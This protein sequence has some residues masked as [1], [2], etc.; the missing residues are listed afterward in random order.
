MG[1]PLLT[2]SVFVYNTP[3]LASAKRTTVPCNYDSLSPSLHPCL[4]RFKL[5]VTLVMN[6]PSCLLLPLGNAHPSQTSG[7]PRTHSECGLK[8]TS[9]TVSHGEMHD[10]DLVMLPYVCCLD[11]HKP[12]RSIPVEWK[13]QTDG[14][15][16]SSC[17]CISWPTLL[18]CGV[19]N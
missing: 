4:Y 12:R 19:R 1:L 18:I 16:G 6:A 7:Q 11:R 10:G 15:S 2:C 3:R 13:T 17:R 8:T 14:P 9:I 5:L